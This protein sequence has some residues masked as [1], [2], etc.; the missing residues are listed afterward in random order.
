M[1]ETETIT[2]EPVAPEAVET[3]ATPDLGDAGKAAIRK[4]REARQQLEKQLKESKE[5]GDALA[6]K[7]RQFEDRDKSETQKLTDQIA[8]LQQQIA[9][10]DAEVAKATLAAVKAEVARVKGVPANRLVGST[11]EEL[12]ADADA[13]LTEVAQRDSKPR[14]PPAAGLKSGASSSGETSANPR[15]A[16]ALALRRMRNGG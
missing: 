14:K 1:P 15:E 2:T 3:D 6:A 13:Y 11:K 10:K 7:V 4:E 8:A 12:E 5:L 9:A 16:A